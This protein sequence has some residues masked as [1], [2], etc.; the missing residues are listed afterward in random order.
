[1][2]TGTLFVCE[3]C[4]SSNLTIDRAMAEARLLLDRDAK[5]LLIGFCVLG[6]FAVLLVWLQ[7]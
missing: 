6:V 7:Q 3:A 1:M 4:A 2:L 5:E